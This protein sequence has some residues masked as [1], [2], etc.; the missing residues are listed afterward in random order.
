[1]MKIT[2]EIKQKNP[3]YDP[4]Y[5]KMFG[6][7]KDD[8]LHTPNSSLSKFIMKDVVNYEIIENGIF[9][10]KTYTIDEN[11]ESFFH[12]QDMYIIKCIQ[13]GETIQALGVSKALIKS[14]YNR[15][16]EKREKADFVVY[17]KDDVVKKDYVALPYGI[18]IL[19]KDFPSTLSPVPVKTLD[20]S[21]NYNQ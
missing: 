14:K 8:P 16:D 20:I 19:E 2:F 15:S 12:I 18:F 1:M 7:E 3:D 4:E 11:E 17:L 9:N 5:K 10:L 13:D 6:F 21:K